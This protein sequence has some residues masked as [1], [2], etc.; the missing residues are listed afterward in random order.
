MLKNLIEEEIVSGKK[1]YAF[2]KHHYAMIPWHEIRQAHGQPIRLLTFDY[3]TD[4]RIAFSGFACQKVDGSTVPSREFVETVS[5]QAVADINLSSLES[6]YESVA[7]LRYDEHIDAAVKSGLISIAFVLSSH[8]DQGHIV[9]NEQRALDQRSAEQ[10]TVRIDG[11]EITLPRPRPKAEPPYTYLIPD[12]K[13]VILENLPVHDGEDRDYKNSVIESCF[14][15]AR[16][17]VVD[18]ICRTSG[19]KRLFEEPF[20]LDIDLDY[21]NTNKSIAP[22]DA[23][24]F[25]ELIRRSTAITIAR[26]SD[27]VQLCQIEGE[28]LNSIE[29]EASL[30]NH[31]Q[32]A[33]QVNIGV[34]G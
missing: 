13:I 33:M 23:S 5:Q 7:R 17:Q 16:L 4:T 6:I 1:M 26:E 25:H 11:E 12:N 10:L 18:D 8:N 28:G 32:T 20:I 14:L 2:E 29:L 34:I 24:V 21:F 3:H 27:C 30:K 31:I 22:N 9:S 15:N 19:I